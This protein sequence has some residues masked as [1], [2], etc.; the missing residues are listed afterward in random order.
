M[1]RPIAFAAVFFIIG[2]VSGRYISGGEYIALTLMLMFFCAFVM[3]SFFDSEFVFIFPLFTVIGLLVFTLNDGYLKEYE[4]DV[5]IKGVVLEA[6]A[7]KDDKQ[8]LV[9]KI[10]EINFD[11]KSENVK[12]KV[13]VYL[14]RGTFVKEGDL[15]VVYGRLNIPKTPVNDGG[16][17]SFTYM[18][19]NG[20]DYSFYAKDVVKF[21]EKPLSPIQLIGKFREKINRTFEII[22]PFKEAGLVKAMVTGETSSIAEDL[23][24]L[25]RNG[26]ISHILAVSGIHTGIIG[27]TLIWIFDFF[28]INRRKSGVIIILIL[29]LYM[30]FAGGRPSVVRAVLMVSIM[31]MGRF[32][33]RLSDGLSSLSLAAVII[34]FINPWQLWDVGFQL[35]FISVLGLI[36]IGERYKKHKGIFKQV[37]FMLKTSFFISIITMPV[38]AW[39]FYEVPLWGCFAN[40]IILPLAG[41]V[42]SF[43]M[44]SGVLGSLNP[45]LGIFFAGPVFGVL[46]IYEFTAEAVSMVPFSNILL[47]RPPFLAVVSFYLIVIILL[48]WEDIGRG[49]IAICSVLALVIFGSMNYE[50]F[51]GISTVDFLDVGQGDCAV[52]RLWNKDTYI[53]DTGGYGYKE[54]GDNTGVKIV[55]PYL[56][57][58]G[59]AEV[60]GIFISHMDSDHMAG[61]FEIIEKYKVNNLYIS[62]YNWKNEEDYIRLTQLAKSKNIVIWE[63]QGGVSA[64]LEKG[65]EISCFYPFEWENKHNNDNS[66]SLVL[67][68]EIGEKR[69]LFTGDITSED[70][71]LIVERGIDLKTDVIKIPHHGSKFSSTHEFLEKAEAEFAV[72]SY[73]KNNVYGHPSWEVVRRLE[74]SGIQVFKTAA[75]GMVTFK[76][77]GTTIK[78]ETMER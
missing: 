39:Y 29:L 31:L 69:F 53:F 63:I 13:K 56:M 15:L 1:K 17:N 32:F 34:L 27:G 60:E 72:I 51:K 28:N 78:A 25:Y 62:R 16:F 75:D 68:L 19:S 48:K 73:G 5:F 58:N 36:L 42:I 41:I 33:H 26:G 77:D 47:G 24:E 8:S 21:G 23:R 76:T 66:G 18:K 46:K 49:E 7:I 6:S 43:A 22:Y 30:F 12:Y 57:S 44:V 3:K 50:R 54:S 52:L 2:I 4:K 9:L 14:P 67:K 70:E 45:W 40:V 35:S 74:E 20:Y 38:I 64:I 37:V 65:I 71:K 55:I 59:I 11:E 61:V 10:D